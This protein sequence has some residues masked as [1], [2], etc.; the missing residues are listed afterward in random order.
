[1]ERLYTFQFFCFHFIK[2][3]YFF[4]NKINFIVEV[5]NSRQ[6]IEKNSII[7]WNKESTSQLTNV[8]LFSQIVN[9]IDCCTEFYTGTKE[10]EMNKRMDELINTN[11]IK[12]HVILI[13]RISD[14]E[15]IFI[16][17]LTHCKTKRK[18]KEKKIP[19]EM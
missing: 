7:R 19:I 2:S 10:K 8:Y 4:G 17:K 1:M 11:L 12:L 3:V 13:S 18:L 5:I 16:N 15:I 14:L 6:N 9:E